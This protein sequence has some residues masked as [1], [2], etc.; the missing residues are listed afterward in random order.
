MADIRRCSVW[1]R[2]YCDANAIADVYSKPI[3][4]DA[5]WKSLQTIDLAKYQRIDREELAGYLDGLAELQDDALYLPELDAWG[6]KYEFYIDLESR[7]LHSF[8]IRSPGKNGLFETN[9]YKVEEYGPLE[10]H[11]DI[12]GVDGYFFYLANLNRF[13]VYPPY[14]RYAPAPHFWS[15]P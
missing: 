9:R 5:L 4:S 3:A 8:C 6:N 14:S 13:Y 2:A 11:R 7:E 12:V 10:F 15:T 1:I